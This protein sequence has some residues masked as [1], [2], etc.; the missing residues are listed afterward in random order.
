MELRTGAR[1]FLDNILRLI[2]LCETVP[3]RL[4]LAQLQA[5]LQNVVTLPRTTMERYVN[6]FMMRREVP[7][8]A[9][10]PMTTNATQASET[11]A[12]TSGS[13]E[14]HLS[15][16][17][18]E[19]EPETRPVNEPLHFLETLS[20]SR[21]D[22]LPNRASSLQNPLRSISDV[23][24]KALH[25]PGTLLSLLP[26]TVLKNRLFPHHP[27]KTEHPLSFTINVKNWVSGYCSNELKERCTP[28]QVTTIVTSDHKAGC[29]LL[30]QEGKETCEQ[31]IRPKLSE[32]QQRQHRERAG[33]SHLPA[34]VTESAAR[35]EGEEL[36]H[37]LGTDSLH[38]WTKESRII[39]DE[40]L[41]PL[42][43]P[44]T[45]KQP[46]D[47]V[48][49]QYQQSHGKLPD[50]FGHRQGDGEGSGQGKSY[51]IN[52][53]Y[54]FQCDPI[55]RDC[56]LLPN[57]PNPTDLFSAKMD[58]LMKASVEDATAIT[59][60]QL[61][62][63]GERAY[64]MG[65]LLNLLVHSAN[66]RVMVPSTYA[67]AGRMLPANMNDLAPD[68]LP[69][70]HFIQNSYELMP[71]LVQDISTFIHTLTERSTY[72]SQWNDQDL[73]NISILKSLRENIWQSNSLLTPKVITIYLN[74]LFVSPIGP[75]REREDN[76]FSVD[77]NEQIRLKDASQGFFSLKENGEL[78]PGHGPCEHFIRAMLM[79]LAAK[80]VHTV[81]P[82]DIDRFMDEPG[83]QEMLTRL[84]KLGDIPDRSDLASPLMHSGLKRYALGDDDQTLP[85]RNYLIRF[86]AQSNALLADYPLSAYD[87]T[88]VV[89]TFWSLMHDHHTPEP[90]ARTAENLK[91][92]ELC[93]KYTMAYQITCDEQPAA[94]KST[95]S[96]LDPGLKREMINTV[97][98]QSFQ[99]QLNTPTTDERLPD[100]IRKVVSDTWQSEMNDYETRPQ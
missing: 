7:T 87:R 50:S 59:Y 47:S 41:H 27:P 20:R 63:A 61:K 18:P 53:D 57:T 92:K 66:G 39:T 54:A 51:A 69:F 17:L 31:I 25:L 45:K 70:H 1:Y 37:Q 73:L 55:H 48:L 68:S 56:Q 58:H 24:G 64:G 40:N 84:R 90:D 14:N 28:E 36:M 29:A 91:I 42:A 96:E 6:R 88:M 44:F 81:K 10:T 46:L 74:E 52:K 100:Q 83:R 35:N 89:D 12:H 26:G 32:L 2:A 34:S 82:R 3:E 49:N 62:A 43:M 93:E 30:G 94:M 72:S 21:R 38:Q 97:A 65:E 95:S 16:F 13:F 5:L 77:A 22:Y 23:L 86:I 85:A 76:V 80:Y 9:E 79:A 11:T 99:T 78:Q 75:D 67:D 15:T 4:S 60:Q 33:Q 98:L 71:A 19:N 8:G